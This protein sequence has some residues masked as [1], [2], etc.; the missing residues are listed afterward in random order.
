MEE[1][2]R[3]KSII[4]NYKPFNEDDSNIVV[5]SENNGKIELV[6]RGVKKIKS[7]LA[8]HVEPISLSNIMVVRGKQY[9]YIGSAVSQN[10]YYNIKNNLD[11]IKFV[12]QAIYIFN[13]IVKK[14]ERDKKIFKLLVD[15]LSVLNE[16]N[17]LKIGYRLLCI[18]FILK[19]IDYLGHTPELYYCL[20]CEKRL[21]PNNNFF[22]FSKGGIVCRNCASPLES[23]PANLGRLMRE[24]ER[25]TELSISDNCIKVLRLII[26]NNLIELVKIK[27]NNQLANEI[28]NTI[29]RFL[30]YHFELKF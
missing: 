5:Y 14:D 30:N 7:K 24:R 1:T 18:F 13:K 27:I 11:K 3:T 29:N 21:I 20:D 25:E 22:N 16:K 26:K 12:G 8:G 2:Y 9:D 19:L 6:A 4:L 15:F 10:C 17:F 28:I 23:L